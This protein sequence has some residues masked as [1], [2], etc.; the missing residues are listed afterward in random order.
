MLYE[1]PG[2]TF[3]YSFDSDAANSYLVLKP[4]S[5]LKPQNHQSEI[6][7]RN[8]DPAFVAFHVRREN[9]DTFIYYNITSKISLSQYLERKRLNRKELLDLLGNIAKSLMLHENYLLELSSFVVHTDFIFINPATAAVSLLYVPVYCNRDSSEVCRTFMKELLVNSANVDDNARDNYMQR[10]LSYLRSGTF[11][12]SD[13][14][15]L[16]ID[17]RYNEGLY[18]AAEKPY[19]EKSEKLHNKTS[20]AC[21][22]APT[23]RSSKGNSCE[24]ISGRKKILRI[25]LIQMLIILPAIIICLF[26]V[27][28]GR[29]DLVS[30]A[31]VMIIAAA[32]DT[33]IM[34][35]IAG[36]PAKCK[37]SHD[38]VERKP[39]IMHISSCR[40]TDSDIYVAKSCDT[41]MISEVPKDNYPYLE[42]AGEQSLERIKLNKS[43]FIIGRLG[44][45]VDHIIQDSTI[46]KL[47]AEITCREGSYYIKD[48]NSKNGTYINGVRIASND[49]HEIKYDCRIR[50][51]GY[52]YIF[53]Q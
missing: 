10:I 48:L 12:L 3:E 40:E 43:R 11:S 26:L 2:L 15:R 46:G 53:R 37:N 29:G 30:I 9:E 42:R 4:D 8:P 28:R 51:S 1:D 47:H 19:C 7:S 20:E 45:M 25:S 39:S 27:S 41:V 14:S 38:T 5:G 13:F 35:R 23:S 36:K 34:K 18:E 24:S 50:F 6:I 22:T 44:S 32:M 49:E 21:C 31:G 52:E 17:L 33:L 16:L